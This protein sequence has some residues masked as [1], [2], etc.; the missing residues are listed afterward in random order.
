MNSGAHFS[1]CRTWRYALWREWDAARPRVMLIGLNPS[2]ADA[3]RND[4]TIRRCIGFARDWGFGGV[5]VLNLF[6]F[7]ATYP[8]DLKMADD[9]VGP[10]NDRWLRRVA[11][12]CPRRV[13]CW[14]N[15]GAFLGRSA[16]VRGL[17]GDRLEVL[18][19]NA[20]GEP[21]HPLYLPKTLWP[22]VWS[23]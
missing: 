6:A 7:R 15:D 1:R 16:R 2:T 12:A 21:A 9:P 17:L 14:G 11:K 10:K 4:P 8:E 5:W 18:R 22:V 19:L 13:A 20:S 3:R 23:K